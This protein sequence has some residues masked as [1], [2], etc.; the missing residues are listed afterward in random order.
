MTARRPILMG[1]ILGLGCL[2]LALV[3]AQAQ[4][5]DAFI[6]Y[7]QKVMQSTGASMGA[8]GDI[9]KNKLPYPGHIY[10]HAQDIQRISKLIGE[11]FK[12]EVSAGKTDAKSELWKEWDKFMAA[13]DALEQESGK[14]ADVAQAGNMEAIGAQVKKLG[15][16]CGNCHKPYRK[17]KE[18]SYKNQK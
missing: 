7:R 11:S 14:L 16:A 4:E 13:A 10:T 8:I 12:K 5:D 15:E 17:P 6:Q 9:L 18:E 2:A 1:F 3:G